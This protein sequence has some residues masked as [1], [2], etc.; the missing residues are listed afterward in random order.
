M[1]A[2]IFSAQKVQMWI[3][4]SL[5]TMQADLFGREI[6][7]L[8]LLAEVNSKNHYAFNNQKPCWMDVAKCLQDSQLKMK[9][10]DRSCLERVAELLKSHHKSEDKSNRA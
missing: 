5:K 2:Y 3:D 8:L 1:S 7:D 6:F 9:V 4:S 10:T